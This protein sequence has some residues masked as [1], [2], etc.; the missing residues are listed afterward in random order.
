MDIFGFSKLI[1]PF[2]SNVFISV[3]LD[4][5]VCS[6]KIMRIKG[7]ETLENLTKEYKMVNHEMP[8]EAV[9]A[10]KSY[11]KKYPFTY[12]STMAKSYNQGI[13]KKNDKEDFSKYGINPKESNILSFGNWKIYIKNSAIEENLEKFSKLKGLDYLFSP[14]IVIYHKIKDQIERK[15]SLYILQER[16]SISLLIADLEGIYFG[17]YFIVEGEAD[18]M[19]EATQSGHIN[20]VFGDG[21]AFPNNNNDDDF[22]DAIDELEDLGDSDLFIDK[23]NES[24]LNDNDEDE[25]TKEK[26]DDIVKVSVIFNI[27]QNS[28]REFYSN[29]LYENKFIEKIVILDTYGMSR[30]GVNYLEENLMIETSK[31]PVSIVD[32]LCALSKIEF[33]RGKL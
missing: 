33:E 18:D 5:K 17:G 25:R 14:F 7:G 19:S 15:T 6:L 20:E 29:E 22:D 8:I 26:V 21:F 13:F 32:E 12:L 31:I 1:R 2:F 10:I 28:L 11:Q 23:L 16:G 9:K 4:S 3:N 24:L 30:G 27:V